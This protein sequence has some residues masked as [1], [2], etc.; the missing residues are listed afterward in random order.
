VDTPD[1]TLGLRLRA[2]VEAPPSG[3]LDRVGV[4]QQ[5]CV[6]ASRFLLEDGAHARGPSLALGPL[7]GAAPGAATQGLRC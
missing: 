3:A 7:S 5:L 6:G 1:A 2:A 4:A